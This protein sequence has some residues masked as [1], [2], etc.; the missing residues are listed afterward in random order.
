MRTLGIGQGSL[1]GQV[2]EK[3]G[4]FG[5]QLAERALRRTDLVADSNEPCA[6]IAKLI[7]GA[8]APV[9]LLSNECT[10][11]R[12]PV[13]PVLPVLLVLQSWRTGRKA[14]S[15]GTYGAMEN[16]AMPAV[17]AVRRSQRGRRRVGRWRAIARSP[18]RHRSWQQV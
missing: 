2:A 15:S 5:F 8:S 12:L 1:R 4:D 11:V 13:L 7:G 16:F 6:R 10:D 3:I 9:I 18:E 14:Y 17:A